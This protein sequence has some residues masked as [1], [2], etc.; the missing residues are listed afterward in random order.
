MER[1]I[2]CSGKVYY[3]LLDQRRKNEQHNVVIIRIEQLYP[4][5]EEELQAELAKY[6]HA[7]ALVLVQTQRTTLTDNSTDT[8]S[9]P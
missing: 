3:E 1:V 4:F 5:P 8:R 7:C 2:F 9:L 6:P